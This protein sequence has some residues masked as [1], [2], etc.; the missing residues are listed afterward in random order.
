MARWLLAQLACGTPIGATVML[1]AMA[2]RQLTPHMLWPGSGKMPGLTEYA[3]GL[4]WSTG[5][6]RVDKIAIA[7]RNG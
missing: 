5:R 7:I 1:L 6:Y 2:K 3:Y 4:G